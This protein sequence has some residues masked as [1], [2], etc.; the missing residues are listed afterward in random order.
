MLEILIGPIASGKSSYC[1][2][3]ARKG[4]IILNDDAIV[5]ALHGGDYSLYDKKLKP[6]YKSIEN[7]IVCT[8]LAMEKRIIIDRPNYSIAMR[9]R[10]IA[11]AKSFDVKVKFVVFKRESPEIHAK[12]RFESDSRGLSLDHWIRAAN[13]HDKLFDLPNKE[14]ELFDEIEYL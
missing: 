13:Y 4:A 3:E 2:Q 9:K 11:I 12:R 10:Y 14:I 8:S 1:S 6:L 7:S 5:T